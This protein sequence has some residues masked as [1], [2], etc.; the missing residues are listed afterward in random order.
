[1]VRN[2][3][4]IALMY[5]VLAALWLGNAAFGPADATRYGFAGAWGALGFGMWL[6][7]ARNRRRYEQSHVANAQLRAHDRNET[8]D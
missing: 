1:M 8:G 6:T 5:G 7:A 3:A 4:R 2:Q